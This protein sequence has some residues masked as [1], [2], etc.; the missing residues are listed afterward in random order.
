MDCVDSGGGLI[1]DEVV[2]NIT[3]GWV[4]EER[5]MFASIESEISDSWWVMLENND[6]NNIK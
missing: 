2:D 5:S 4:V 3:E 6:K 1:E